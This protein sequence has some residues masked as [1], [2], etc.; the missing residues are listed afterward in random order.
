MDAT[1]KPST[2]HVRMRVVAAAVAIR[3][4]RAALVAIAWVAFGFGALSAFAGVVWVTTSFVDGPRVNRAPICRTG[5]HHNCLATYDARVESV[6]TANAV[7]ISYDDGRE[8][9]TLRLRGDAHPP[10]RAFVRAELWGGAI[11]AISNRQGRRYKD[12][13]AKERYCKK[14]GTG[15]GSISKADPKYAKKKS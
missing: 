13:G 8:H 1:W 6:D 11:V 7:Q 12:D 2:L 5:Q 3:G 4:L 10:V 15:M 9:T 14:C